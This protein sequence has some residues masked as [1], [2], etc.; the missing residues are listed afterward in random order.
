MNTVTGLNDTDLALID[1]LDDDTLIQF[2]KLSQYSQSVCL[3]PQIQQRIDLYKRY[4]Q[5]DVLSTEV[6][7]HV[8]KLAT[9]PFMLMRFEKTKNKDYLQ[10]YNLF[11]I[12]SDDQMERVYFSANTDSYHSTYKI[13]HQLLDYQN[14]EHLLSVY[15]G[16]KSYAL[17]YDIDT[18]IKIYQANGLEKYA[19]MEAHQSIQHQFD[20]VT[21]CDTSTLIGFYNMLEVY[22]WFEVQCLFL[23]L[24][25]GGVIERH[26]EIDLDYLQS[27]YGVKIVN[28]L[29]NEIALYYDLMIQFVNDLVL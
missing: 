11:F 19:K 5:F 10:I 26:V 23:N 12:L 21:T 22:Y 6:L 25:E 29:K 2:C 9:R 4:K 17:D 1:Q 15:Q 28:D 14:G 7:N 24:I 16:N 27:D 18:L 3:T 20:L 8:D 13:S